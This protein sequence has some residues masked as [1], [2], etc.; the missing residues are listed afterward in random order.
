MGTTTSAVL[1]TA[2]LAG[3]ASPAGAALV[4]SGFESG[5]HGQVVASQ[6][7]AS[8]G[9]R[10]TGANFKGGPNLAIL[11]DSRR[12]GTA[13]P[14]LQ[15]PWAGGN[16]RGSAASGNILILA[17]NAV[18][19][20]R[21][22]RID[23]PD[24]QG[25][26][27]GSAGELRFAFAGI[28]ASL[29]LDLIDVDGPAEAAV[30]F[31]GFRRNGV[32]RARVRFS[33]FTDPASDFYDPTIRFGDRFANRVAPI[34]AAD[35]GITGFDEVVVNTGLCCAVDGLRVGS[36]SVPEPSVGA[37]GVALVIG[38]TLLHRR[39]SRRRGGAGRFR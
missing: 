3:L 8:D 23:S 21:D 2:A 33:A 30:G 1:A 11:F 6:Y 25:S 9:V 13:D 19:A 36:A 24:D 32:E 22:G 29:A 10:I 14:D 12:T 16:L 34:T 15:G 38:G 7:L 37:I 27:A 4:A 28:K 20:D 39:R 35:L 5:A 17:E 18:D 31:I 26:A